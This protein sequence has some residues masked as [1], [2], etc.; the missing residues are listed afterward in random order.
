M[1]STCNFLILVAFASLFWFR[2]GF[3]T[4][5]LFLGRISI[6]LKPT[7][8]MDEYELDF[9]FNYSSVMTLVGLLFAV[10][11]SSYYRQ[12]SRTYNKY[13]KVIRKK[14]NKAF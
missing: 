5:Q 14:Y 13:R 11:V 8:S 6:F 12:L 7:A 2:S 3:G 9:W 1:P 10:V 4:A